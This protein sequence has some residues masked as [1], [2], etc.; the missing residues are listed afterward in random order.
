MSILAVVIA[1]AAYGGRGHTCGR[2]RRERGRAD[3]RHSVQQPQRCRLP[4]EW[5][6]LTWCD[7]VLPGVPVGS[8]AATD[9]VIRMISLAGIGGFFSNRAARPCGRLA[10]VARLRAPGADRW[11]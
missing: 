9:S 4:P 1:R 10:L 5:C 8:F 6:A 7:A 11:M 2:R 3:R